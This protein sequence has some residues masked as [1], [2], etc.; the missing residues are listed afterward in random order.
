MM[1]YIFQFGLASYIGGFGTSAILLNITTLKNFM[2]VVWIISVSVFFIITIFLPENLLISKNSFIIA[3][4][5]YKEISQKPKPAGY[6][7]TYNSIKNYLDNL[8]SEMFSS[9]VE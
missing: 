3:R 8:P 1:F 2:L 5:V 4:R 7:L 6:S 9:T